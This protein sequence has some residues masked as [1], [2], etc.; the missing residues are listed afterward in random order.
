[1]SVLRAVK[2]PQAAPRFEPPEEPP[3]IPEPNHPMPPPA[4]PAI[5]QVGRGDADVQGCVARGT[6]FYIRH[7]MKPAQARARAAQ[8]CGASPGTKWR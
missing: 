6:E 7:G 1:M 8:V 4:P 3:E 5:P 2:E